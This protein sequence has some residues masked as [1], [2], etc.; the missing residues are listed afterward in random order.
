LPM[1]IVYIF[2]QKWIIG[3]VMRGSLK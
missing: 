1:I 2:V 3:G